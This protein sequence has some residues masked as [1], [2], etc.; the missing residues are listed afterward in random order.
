MSVGR[1]RGTR[2][3]GATCGQIYTDT[4]GCLASRKAHHAGARGTAPQKVYMRPEFGVIR[5]LHR[6]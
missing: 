1:S 6:A 5:S 2:D 3:S 4:R